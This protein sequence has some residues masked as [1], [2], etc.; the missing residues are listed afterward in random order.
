ME[1][2]INK[3]ERTNI[4]DKYCET[5]ASTTKSNNVRKTDLN[6]E[7]LFSV[8]ANLFETV[9]GL[10]ISEGTVSNMLNAMRRLSKKTYEMIRRKDADGKVAGADV[11]CL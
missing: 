7:P 5:N 8:Q 6:C 10:H 11:P 9:F 3:Q 4:E 2:I 1:K